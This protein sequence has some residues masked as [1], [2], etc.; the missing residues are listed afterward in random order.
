MSIAFL[1][2]KWQTDVNWDRDQ[3]GLHVELSLHPSQIHPLGWPGPWRGL[4]RARPRTTSSLLNHVI[5]SQVECNL[6]FTIKLKVEGENQQ[7]LGH[8]ESRVDSE[9]ADQNLLI[10]RPIYLIYISN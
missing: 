4:S 8:C 3:V 5:V 6:W 10:L 2:C 7:L 1:S 9:I